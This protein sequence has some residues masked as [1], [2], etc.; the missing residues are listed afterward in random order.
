M[1]ATPSP[2]TALAASLFVGPRWR[3]SYVHAQPRA[4]AAPRPPERRAP[5]APVRGP[6]RYRVP[7]R[8]ARD[9]EGPHEGRA[10]PAPRHS[11]DRAKLGDRHPPACGSRPAPFAREPRAS[12]SA[13][14]SSERSASARSTERFFAC[15]GRRNGSGASL[16]TPSARRREAT[17]GPISGMSSACSTGGWRAMCARST[18]DL[19]LLRRDRRGTWT[20]G[21]VSS[22][23]H[24]LWSWRDSRTLGSRPSS[25]ASPRPS[26]RSPTIRSRRSRSRSATPTWGSTACRWSTPPGVLG[27][28]AHANPAEKEAQ[29]AVERAATLVLFV[30]DPTGTCGYTIDEQERLLARW[31]E[32]FPKL[33]DRGGGD[34]VRSLAPSGRTAFRSPPHR[35]R[36]RALWGET[37][38]RA[39]PSGHDAGGR[40]RTGGRG[41][42]ARARNGRRLGG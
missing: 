31:R 14:W 11:Q 34:E 23:E 5:A 3:R 27:R 22:R 41:D 37:A 10:R 1:K 32:E 33:P 2:G 39:S 42:G 35:R 24:R 25:G 28:S 29:T 19:A 7:P 38:F 30:L 36:P 9:S 16:G 17:G 6:P 40:R 4:T 13:R 21:P 15:A 18:A 20:T 12:S 26:R 8:V